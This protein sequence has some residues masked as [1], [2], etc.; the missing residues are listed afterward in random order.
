M[1]HAGEPVDIP[2]EIVP[3][4]VEERRR[5][6][7]AV[8]RRRG[9][10]NIREVLLRDRTKRMSLDDDDRDGDDG[11]DREEQERELNALVQALAVA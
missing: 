11:G 5:Y 3:E 1:N 9:R 6:A 4:T 8:A 2:V 7:G 10:L